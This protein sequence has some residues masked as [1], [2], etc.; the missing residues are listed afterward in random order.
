MGDAIVNRL[1]EQ[2]QAP[3]LAW[4]TEAVNEIERLRADRDRWRELAI[5]FV[6]D[7]YLTW[8]EARRG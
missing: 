8:Q 1:R 3:A 4:L 6:M 5:D 2:A 7:D